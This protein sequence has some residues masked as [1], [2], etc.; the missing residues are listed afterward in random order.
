MMIRPIDHIT[1]YINQLTAID[2]SCIVGTASLIC[3]VFTCLPKILPTIC[4]SVKDND[5]AKGKRCGS[6][7]ALLLFIAFAWAQIS[8][9]E[10]SA[11]VDLT[12]IHYRWRYDNGP[13]GSSDYFKIQ[14]GNTTIVAGQTSRT[15]TAGTDYT[16]PSAASKAFVRI[17]STRLSAA[18]NTTGGGNQPP[19]IAMAWIDDTNSITSSIV[20]Q[21]AASTGDTRITYEIIEYL[22][23]GGGANEIVV[24]EAK[25][26]STT[27]AT[28]TTSAVSGI[29]DDSAI[30]VFITGQGSNSNANDTMDRGLFT[31][32]WLAGSDQARFTRGDGSDTGYVSYAVVEFI[33]SNWRNVQRE[34]HSYSAAATWEY[35]T[36]NTT[37]LDTSKTFLHVQTRSTTGNLDEQSGEVYLASTTQIGFYL[38]SGA[39][40]NPSNVVWVIENTQS[41]A[42]AMSVARYSGTR[43]GG[44]EPYYEDLTITAADSLD[45]TSIWGESARSTGTGTAV[46]RGN[47]G[48]ELTAI[49]TV[50]LFASDNGQTQNY[51][52]EIVQWPGAPIAGASWAENEDTKQNDTPKGVLKRLR[53]QV[54]N[55]GDTGSA[56]E[57][58]QLQ[59]AETGTCSSG[60]YSAVPTGT[61]GDWQIVG[62]SYI[63]DGEATTNMAGGLSDAGT[64]FVLGELKDAGNTTSSITLCSRCIFYSTNARLTDLITPRCER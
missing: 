28:A 8:I 38:E 5:R 47:L 13:E 22:G 37:L 41:G 32:E 10:A 3:R 17:V 4:D 14:H 11:A 31:S 24:R 53:F 25:E 51:R 29:S 16:A 36:L 19:D 44:T 63:T 23:T 56:G 48:L 6:I 34:E 40:L 52:Y 42:D 43:S 1:V 45:T 49:S 35:E 15:L 21:R 60:S 50:Q 27:G 62:S 54:H 30:A 46:P 26:I 2:E 20:F 18:G 64:T 59:V 57:T 33:G 12:Q 55:A 39:S 58:Y 61:S 9:Q 7:L